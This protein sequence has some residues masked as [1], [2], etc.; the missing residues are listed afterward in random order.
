MAIGGKMKACPTIHIYMEDGHA[1]CG[2]INEDYRDR[3]MT[4][5]AAR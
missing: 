5:T 2:L 4:P 3:E 1:F